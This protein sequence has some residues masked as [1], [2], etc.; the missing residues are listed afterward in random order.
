MNSKALPD[1]N[2]AASFSELISNFLVYLAT[3]DSAL[4]DHE[5]CMEAFKQLEQIV[6]FAFCDGE[7]IC[8]LISF[9]SREL[10]KVSVKACQELKGQ[11]TDENKPLKDS[12][13][14]M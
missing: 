7:W 5:N 9:F 12:L 14:L 13:R 6:S 10:Y 8:E 3:K 11:K 4:R 2:L 1:V